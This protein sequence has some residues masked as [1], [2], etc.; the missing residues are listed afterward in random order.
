ML[1]SGTQQANPWDEFTAD[2]NAEYDQTNRSVKEINQLIEQCQTELNRMTQK[3]TTITTQLQQLHSSLESIPRQD[4]RNLY[5]SAL[6][7]QQRLLIMRGQ[8]EKLQTGQTSLKKYQAMLEKVR[9]GMENNKTASGSKKDSAAETVQMLINAQE[10]E[11]QRLSRQMH[12]GPAQALSNFILQTEIAMRLFEVDQN[13]AKDELTSLKNSALTTFQKVRNFIFELRPMMLDDLGL[14]P[15]IKRYVDTFKEQ[16]GMD[17]ELIITGSETR[18]ASYLEVMIFRSIQDLLGNA[19]RHSQ[20]SKT[21]VLLNIETD[22][23][24]V[25][26]DDNG[27]GYQPEELQ[28]DPNLGIKLMRDRV[29]MLGGRS[30]ID[31]VVGQGTRITIEMPMVKAAEPAAK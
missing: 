8:L 1:N 23:V 11:R 4:I 3:N 7:T 12:D 9:K 31:S 16:T 15:T 2:I 24:R 27:K 14:V 19:A 30:E 25:S 26:V 13:R 17:V 6:D 28:N 5:D 10:V 29:E 22:L 20:A 21:K 18:M